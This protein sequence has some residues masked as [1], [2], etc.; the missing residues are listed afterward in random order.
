MALEKLRESF[1]YLK[2]MGNTSH[3]QVGNRFYQ[4]Y[5]LQQTAVKMS[6]ALLESGNAFDVMLIFSEMY[7]KQA[8]VTAQRQNQNYRLQ[9]L[10]A[11]SQELDGKIVSAGNAS[12]EYIDRWFKDESHAEKRKEMQQEGNP[13][14]LRIVRL[15]EQIGTPEAEALRKEIK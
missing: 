7:D 15:L 2:L 9:E 8:W 6:R 3:Y 14:M 12:V 10:D 13:D 11:I 1:H 5:T 4:S